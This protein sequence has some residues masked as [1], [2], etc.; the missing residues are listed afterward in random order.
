MNQCPDC[1]ISLRRVHIIDVEEMVMICVKC[2]KLYEL[3]LVGW[4]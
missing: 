4:E 3:K 1:K 2:K